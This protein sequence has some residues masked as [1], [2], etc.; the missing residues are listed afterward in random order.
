MNRSE[1][2][3]D[4]KYANNTLQKSKQ[5]NSFSRNVYSSFSQLER[6][7]LSE[8]S[9]LAKKHGVKTHSEA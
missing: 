5:T 1:Y 4:L 6:S 3:K 2:A 8:L 7:T 9:P